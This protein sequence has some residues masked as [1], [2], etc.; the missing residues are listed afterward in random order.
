[1]Q[2]TI[3]HFTTRD[4]VRLA[5]A[6]SGSGPTLVKASNWLTHL[7]YDWQ[8]PVWRHWLQFLSAHFSLLRYDER[9]CGLSQR[10]VEDVA[11]ANWLPD[12]EDLV[13]AAQPPTPHV[14]L[15]ISQGACAALA[16]AVR[17][18]QRVSHLV[19][20]GSYVQ[21]WARTGKPEH[22]RI[23]RSVMDMIEQHWGRCDPQYRASFVS[24]F[25]PGGNA[26]QL[27]WYDE[28]CARCTEPA[29]AAR[30]FL[31]RGD[32]DLGELPL[33]VRV[34]TLVLHAGGDQV[35]PARQGQALA[36]RIPGA[37]FVQL[38]SCNHILLEDEPAWPRLRALLLD[39]TGTA[40]TGIRQ[41]PE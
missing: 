20:Y 14:M 28:L 36:E 27:S 19:L 26:Q 7:E 16:Y 33:Q 25:A 37:E 18:P 8:S 38:D 4:H 6:S 30:L 1:M 40:A 5:W 31:S 3:R 21:G 22:L 34:P 10:E 9:G 41:G 11:A 39:F 2:Q 17:Y 15:G 32:A 13:A 12:L 23:G 35:A 24:R 29:M